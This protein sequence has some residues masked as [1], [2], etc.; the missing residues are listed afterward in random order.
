[1]EKKN[2][3]QTR[4]D[5]FKN[6]V[7]GALPILGAIILVNNPLVG[8]AAE[9]VMGCKY[10]CSSG[11]YKSCNTGCESSCYGTCKHACEGCK[12]TCSGGCKN[13]CEGTC[14]YSSR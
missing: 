5:F 14:K 9:T 12:Y 11:C 3:I 1:M 4:R 2:K 10:G 8:K 7:K 13:S 6:A